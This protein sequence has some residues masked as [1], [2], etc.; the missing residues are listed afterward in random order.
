MPTYTNISLVVSQNLAFVAG[1]YVQLSY[2]ANNY[3]VGKVVSYNKANGNLTITPTQI[4][5]A[6]V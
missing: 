4:G 1:D 3:I 6:H 2:D 5:R